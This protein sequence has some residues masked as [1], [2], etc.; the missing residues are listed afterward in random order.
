MKIIEKATPC[1]MEEM[2]KFIKSINTELC[3]SHDYSK[4]YQK[5]LHI[6]KSPQNKKETLEERK[7]NLREAF[8]YMLNENKGYCWNNFL[9]WPTITDE[10]AFAISFV[11]EKKIVIEEKK[12]FYTF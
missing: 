8:V 7:K 12:P 5:V 9:F 11:N 10:G 3:R 6:Y 4:T 2:V 1:Y